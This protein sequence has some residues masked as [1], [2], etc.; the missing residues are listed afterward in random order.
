MV[1]DPRAGE[2]SITAEAHRG[3]TRCKMTFLGNNKN[4]VATLGKGR[5]KKELALW[6]LRKT[7]QR[8]NNY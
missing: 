8:I 2:V 4:Y 5:S 6:D 1:V 3:N 7:D